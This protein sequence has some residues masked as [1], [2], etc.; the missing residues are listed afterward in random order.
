MKWK[1]IYIVKI[2][3][4]L[5]IDLFVKRESFR[6]NRSQMDCYI[7]MDGRS[8]KRFSLLKIT[9][10]LILKIVNIRIVIARVC[11]IN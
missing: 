8:Y 9:I 4:R 3:S 11:E 6:K 10:Y 2:R 7:I 1:G 5:E